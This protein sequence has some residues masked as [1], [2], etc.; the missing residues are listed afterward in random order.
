MQDNAQL[1]G[2]A[3][4]PLAA[5]LVGAMLH[6]QPA[7][8]PGIDAAMAHPL[9]WPPAKRLAFLIDLSNRMEPED[10]EAR[11]PPAAL[12]AALPAVMCH[13]AGQA[14][15]VATEA[16]HQPPRL[17]CECCA[18]AD[19]ALL[20]ALEGFAR[21]AIGGA[22]WQACLSAALR[23][24]LGRYRRYNASSLRDLLRVVRNKHN[25]FRELPAGLQASLGPVPE[26]FL[27]CAAHAACA[28]G[29]WR[30]P[31]RAAPSVDG[32]AAPWAA[33]SEDAAAAPALQAAE[34]CGHS[35]GSLAACSAGE[36]SAVCCA[37]AVAAR[38]TR[39]PA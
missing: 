30:L 3:G 4:Q 28:R 14:A 1:G 2:L 6:Q 13:A 39:N 16:R 8:R 38:H 11:V 31:M 24:N 26:G 29:A 33:P 5:H 27:R 37:W 20:A 12:P 17:R 19:Q 36:H 34:L 9:W 18:Q 7:Q 21:T 23:D 22:D 32:A 15:C 35:S 25:H 10:R